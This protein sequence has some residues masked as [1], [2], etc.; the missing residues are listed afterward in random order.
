[1]V[2]SFP[3]PFVH[4]AGGKRSPT[5]LSCAPGAAAACSTISAALAAYGVPPARQLLGTGSGQDTIRVLVGPW[6]ALRSDVA[7]HQLESGPRLSGVYA[8]PDAAGD[9]IE[10][11]DAEGHAVRTLGAGAG[12]IAATRYQDQQPTWVITGTDAAGVAAAARAVTATRLR[13]RFA[14]AIAPAGGSLPLPLR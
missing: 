4:G 8:R 5:T 11:L 10:L 12:L 14:L 1:V 13:H 3:E 6:P 9:A 2:G 7:A